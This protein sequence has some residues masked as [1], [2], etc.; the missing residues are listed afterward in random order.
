MANNHLFRTWHTLNGH[1]MEC[2]FLLYLDLHKIAS[3]RPL[4]GPPIFVSIPVCKPLHLKLLAPCY[5]ANV[6]FKQ[7]LMHYNL[8]TD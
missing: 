7:V 8:K 6:I 3:Y 2:L 4:S 5:T 1:S